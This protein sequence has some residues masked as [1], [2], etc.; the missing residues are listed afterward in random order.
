MSVE[1]SST[2]HQIEQS[3]F[4]NSIRDHHFL[5]GEYDVFGLSVILAK[6]SYRSLQ[7]CHALMQQLFL[8]ISFALS[9]Q[10]PSAIQREKKT[11]LIDFPE[12]LLFKLRKLVCRIDSHFMFRFD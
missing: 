8:L 10:P 7:M 5:E 12:S 1:S 2:Y 4:S 3:N 9:P 11:D 6:H